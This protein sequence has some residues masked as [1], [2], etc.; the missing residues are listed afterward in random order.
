[1]LS[2]A[3][4]NKAD[5]ADK[6]HH[7]SMYCTRRGCSQVW[8]KLGMGSMMDSTTQEILSSATEF[9]IGICIAQLRP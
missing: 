8:C 9:A 5:S 6:L 3:M 1:M 4:A 2:A 7:K